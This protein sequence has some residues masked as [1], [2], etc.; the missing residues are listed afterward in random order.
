MT[1]LGVAPRPISVAFVVHTMQMA[2]AERLVVETIRR[3][4]PWIR[5]TVC[6][7]DALGSLGAELREQC[8]DVEV[9]DRRPGLDLRVPGRLAAIFRDRAVQV[10]HAHQY[11][12]FFYTAFAK[13]MLRRR[14]RVILT[15]H[16]RH[17]PDIVSSRRRSVNALA[18]SRLADRV[19]AV[20]SFSAGA[21]ATRD[22]F[23][24]DRIEVIPN[25]VELDQYVPG[26]TRDAARRAAGLPQGRLIV[27][28][29]RFH[30]VKDQVT[31]VRGF[32]AAAVA[33]PDAQL[34]LA[35]DGPLRPVLEHLAA[36]LGVAD[37]VHFLGVRTDVPVLLQ[38]ADVFCLTSLSE[39]A[40]LTV[41]EAMAAAAPIVLTDVGGNPELVRNGM[42][43]LLV[44]RGDAPAAGAAMARLLAD[45]GLASRLAAAAAERVRAHF[46]LAATIGRYFELYSELAA[47]MPA[48]MTGVVAARAESCE[49]S[50]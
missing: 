2:G 50:F 15:E 48:P 31:L 20:C 5:P 14:V 39:A 16:G 32:A 34:I 30:P 37:R 36:T 3:L 38:A 45:Q 25:G 19:N 42:E 46:P 13:L 35:G 24:R 47:L 9:L 44:P 12:P 21:L 28:I 8:V 17:Y 7:L 22:G 6:C 18:L 4:G 29:A 26:M 1:T 11:T 33:V 49:S 43:G 41:L 23:R 40:S 10:V 27:S